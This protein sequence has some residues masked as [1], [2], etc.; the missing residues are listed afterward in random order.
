SS[1]VCSSDLVTIISVAILIPIATG[2]IQ[3]KD[4]I[5]AMKIPAGWIAVVCGI[6]VA[7]LSKHGVNWLSSTPQVTVAL[8]IGTI[9]GVV[10]S[11]GVAAG[12]MIATAITDYIS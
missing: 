10:F 12:R 11:K 9:I 2:Q 1:D 5:N 6:L 4:L 8:V 7:I 3:F